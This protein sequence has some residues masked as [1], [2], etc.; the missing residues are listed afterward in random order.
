MKIISANQKTL[1]ELG[2]RP[3]DVTDYLQ[4]DE[5]IAEYLGMHPVSDSSS[6]HITSSECKNPASAGF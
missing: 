4:T 2:I 5:D 3:F 6:S 1:K